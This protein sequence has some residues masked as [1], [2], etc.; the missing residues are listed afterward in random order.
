MELGKTNNK[1][2]THRP[3]EENRVQKSIHTSV[4]NLFSTNIPRTYNG[5]WESHLVNS[6]GNWIFPC[7]RMKVDPSLT[8]AISSTKIHSK[9]IKYL[10]D[11]KYERRKYR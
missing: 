8:T 5:G 10:Q 2:Q 1:K 3:R 11:L 6:K 7:R 4:I 9:W